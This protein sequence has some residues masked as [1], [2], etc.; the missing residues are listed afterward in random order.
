MCG[1]DSPPA[2]RRQ[3]A[4]PSLANV[5]RQ[6]APLPASQPP[7]SVTSQSPSANGINPRGILGPS[8]PAPCQTSPMHSPGA[9]RT[10]VAGFPSQSPTVA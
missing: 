4:A 2:R 7:R 8:A 1:I 5:S 10:V 6:T 3:R 9:M